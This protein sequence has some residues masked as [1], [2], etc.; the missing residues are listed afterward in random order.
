MSIP[1]R[2][3]ESNFRRFE[4][5]FLTAL[6]VYPTAIVVELPPLS[7]RTVA[8][9]LR[10]AQISVREFKWPTDLDIVKL[11]TLKVFEVDGVVWLGAQP[12]NK[13]KGAGAVAFQVQQADNLATWTTDEL[14][15]IALLISNQR[16]VS[17]LTIPPADPAT[18]LD[19]E[20]KFNISFVHQPNQTTLIL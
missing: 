7:L 15:A 8:A 19:L 9:R 18:C 20:A 13:P 5:A 1:S 16:I 14:A 4:P 11:Q 12:P 17:G 3:S 10:D 6:T 2:L